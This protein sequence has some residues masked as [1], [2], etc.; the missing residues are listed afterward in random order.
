MNTT[1]TTEKPAAMKGE[2]ILQDRRFRMAV[3]NGEYSRAITLFLKLQFPNRANLETLP[4]EAIA[5]A[6][7]FVDNAFHAKWKQEAE[8]AKEMR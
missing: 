8:M 7:V 3:Q 6:Q 5:G 4:R 1:E 2:Q